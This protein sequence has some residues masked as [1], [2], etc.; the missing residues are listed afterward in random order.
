MRTESKG[1]TIHIMIL[2]ELAD[3]ATESTAMGTG[4]ESDG[5]V[6]PTVQ[7]TLSYKCI[8]EYTEEQFE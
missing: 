2:D 5:I 1:T 3:A 4:L 7:Q 8:Q 6:S